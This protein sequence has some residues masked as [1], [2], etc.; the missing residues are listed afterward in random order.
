MDNAA[1]L[2]PEVIA[3]MIDHFGAR[4]DDTGAG[5]LRFPLRH[6]HATARHEHEADKSK[7][8]EIEIVDLAARG[9][10][11]ETSTPVTNGT[12]FT[13]ELE[14]PGVRRQTWHCRVVNVHTF[15]G[16]LFRAGARFQ[17]IAN[18]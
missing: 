1:F 10:G 4:A 5:Y 18:A 16:T 13:V 6:C 9:I 15:D 7:A 12:A 8:F 11:F 2:P 17:A 3:G 14:V